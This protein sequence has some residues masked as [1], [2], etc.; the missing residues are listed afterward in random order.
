MNKREALNVI[1]KT[2][3]YL[4]KN[5]VHEND[6]RLKSNRRGFIEKHNNL[7]LTYARLLKKAYEVLNQK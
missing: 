4:A 7:N 6:L 3:A 5:Q 2:G 1:L